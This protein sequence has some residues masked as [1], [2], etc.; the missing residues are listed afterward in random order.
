MLVHPSFY[1]KRKRNRNQYTDSI[2]MSFKTIP[3]KISNQKPA[4]N[5]IVSTSCP[6][7]K[8]AMM[9]NIIQ[10][11]NGPYQDKDVSKSAPACILSDYMSVYTSDS[12]SDSNSNSNSNSH[13]D[14]LYSLDGSDIDSNEKVKSDEIFDG[15]FTKDNPIIRKMFEN[16]ANYLLEQEK[17][18]TEIDH[19]NTSIV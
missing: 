9:M 2:N 5:Y 4:S 16:V 8:I 10:L 3:I 19:G 13:D 18:D 6:N 17:L 11:R 1:M 15:D 12:D 14:L 7:D